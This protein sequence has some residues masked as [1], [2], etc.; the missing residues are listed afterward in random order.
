MNV[1]L[2]W[3]QDHLDLSDRKIDELADMLTFAGIEVEGIA[4]RGASFA[5]VLV[6]QIK[7]SDQH[8]NADRLSVC[9]VDDG[10][11]DLRQ[12]VCGAKN[13]KVGDKVPLAVPGAVLPGD[14]KIK[15]GKLRGVE[16]NGMMCSG[17]ELGLSD[18]HQG[19]LI[20]SEDAPVGVPIGDLFES[21][22]IFELEI[23]PNRPDLLSHLGIARE[24]AALAK[25]DLQGKSQHNETTAKQ[26]AATTKEI[27]LES[28]EVCPYYTARSIRG[29]NVGESPDWLKRKL[30]AV[31]LRP[32]NNVVDIT[33]YVLMEMGQPLHAFDADKLEGGIRVR[34]AAAG[35][36]LKA[37]DGE[38][39]TLDEHDLVIADQSKALAI[40]GV[41][42]GDE[43]G[44][45][46]GT[47]NLLLESAYFQPAAIRRTSRRLDLSSDSS[48]RFERGVDPHQIAGASELATKLILECAGGE[49]EDVLLA[50]GEPPAAPTPVTL[51][52]DRATRLLGVPLASQDMA[53]ILSG[54]GFRTAEGSEASTT[55]EI[56]TFRLDIERHVDLVEE[57]ARVYGIDKIPARECAIFSEAS[58]EDARYD[59]Y[60]HLRKRLVSL[61]YD[62]CLTIKLI[63]ETQLQDDLCALRLGGQTQAVP[64]KKPLSQDH[65]RLRPSVLPGLLDVAARNI[66]QGAS[67]LRFFE[68][69]TVF[70]KHEK[71]PRV[72]ESHQLGIV[73]AG[74]ADPAS[75]HH[76][77]P[78]AADLYDLI[79]LLEWLFESGN[80]KIRLKPVE[81]EKLV[82]AGDV[83]LGK[84]VIGRAGQAWP[85]RGR[86][87]DCETPLFVA[88]IDLAK[89]LKLGAQEDP[90]QDLPKFP[91]V[92][93]DVALEVPADMPQAD[94]AAIFQKHNEVLLVDFK[95][96]DVFADPSG[97]KLAADR[98]SLAYSI[99]YRSTDRTLKSEEVD[100]AHGKVLAALTKNP[101]VNV[102]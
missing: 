42:G 48:Y 70:S 94:I 16:S 30:E 72:L 52:H 41:M 80:Q 63:S 62:D 25:L 74:D 32:I 57:L 101:Q 15:A 73:L 46:E 81:S 65:T 5:N 9:Q 78:R 85:A 55:W 18:D 95:L 20:L 86:A 84:T 76:G 28:P 45:V 53:A 88:E 82:L 19:L 50:A 14:F 67:I 71:S 33:N 59:A 91:A 89:A 44:V 69:G 100:K 54:L 43:T 51:D 34:P 17:K 40:G 68:I 87:M 58:K 29:V 8:P 3:L 61:G 11:G 31:G 98:K 60:L 1:S 6:A 2:N 64:L 37:L 97:E 79:G 99:T 24:L 96:F 13:Y 75:W 27:Q 92:T 102:R 39:Y 23:T 56:P 49:A 93:R 7:S 21:D 83:L 38:D 77:Q 22:T 47:V 35:E 26:Q 66:R 12:I 10:S 90:V 36:V 4:S